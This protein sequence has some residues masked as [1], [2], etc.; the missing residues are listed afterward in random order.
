MERL[1]LMLSAIA[2]IATVLYVIA[3]FFNS[4]Y[5]SDKEK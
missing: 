1:S 5:D 4:D 3:R 2:L